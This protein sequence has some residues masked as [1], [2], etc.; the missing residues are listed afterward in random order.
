MSNF[1]T[2]TGYWLDYNGGIPRFSIGTG[3]DGT[4]SAGFSWNG[5]VAN[6]VGGGTFSGALSAA[7]GTFAGSL[8]AATGSF[9]GSLSAA[10]GS[11]AG[12][13]TVGSSPAVSGTTMT[14]SGAVLNSNGTFA[15]GNSTANISFNG[16]T[17]TFN[18]EVVSNINLK[19]NS[20]SAVY[21]SGSTV[22]S[23]SWTANVFKTTGSLVS[24]VP[25]TGGRGNKGRIVLTT[26]VNVKS[27]SGTN[28]GIKVGFQISSDGGTI[29]QDMDTAYGGSLFQFY[30]NNS[31]FTSTDACPL[32][33][34]DVLGAGALYPISS[35]TTYLVRCKVA[36]TTSH[37]TS[38]T[39]D[40]NLVAMDLYK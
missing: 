13:V 6:F 16:S 11:F 24:I 2:G 19:N 22:T 4:L 32:P 10:T 14:G 38:Y 27:T 20:T 5:S 37:T 35:N 21:T 33:F 30:T 3:S 26:T 40:F 31:S 29:W 18:G 15:I 1:A 9:A 23:A 34:T 7:S 17:F 28:R 36:F 8:S 12:T 25:P 39:F